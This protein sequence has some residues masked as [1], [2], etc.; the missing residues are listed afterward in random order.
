M[1]IKKWPNKLGWDIQINEEYYLEVFQSGGTCL[2]EAEFG[3]C[4]QNICWKK[5]APPKNKKDLLAIAKDFNCN[6]KTW[7]EHDD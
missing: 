7:E 5:F 2:T 1:R 3:F 6:R 4:G